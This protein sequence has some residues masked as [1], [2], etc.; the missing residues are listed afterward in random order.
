MR[1]KLKGIYIQMKYYSFLIAFSIMA[2][3]LSFVVAP[4][5]AMILRFTSA[6]F[7]VGFGIALFHAKKIKLANK[8]VPATFATSFRSDLEKP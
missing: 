3:A 2:G 6:V 1:I 7:L 5:M 4:G 8:P